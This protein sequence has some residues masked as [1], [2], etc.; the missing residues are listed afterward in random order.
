[1]MEGLVDLEFAVCLDLHRHRGQHPR[2]QPQ[3]SHRSQSRSSST[4]YCGKTVPT[5]FKSI[6]CICIRRESFLW[7]P[8]RGTF[9]YVLRK[10]YACMWRGK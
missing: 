2:H 1:M 4:T 6:L 5:G 7:Q 8:A 9:C 10:H 3:P